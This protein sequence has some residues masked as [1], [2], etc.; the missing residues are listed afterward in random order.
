MS[1]LLYQRSLEQDCWARINEV[2]NREGS[3]PRSADPS[4][5]LPQVR[6]GSSELAINTRCP[7]FGDVALEVWAGDPRLAPPD[8][9]VVFDGTLRTVA[10]GFDVGSIATIF[11][12]KA[13]PG[14]YRVRAE[15]HRDDVGYVDAVRFIFPESPDLEGDALY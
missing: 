7:D 2:G 12:A 14:L 10:N 13:A 5:P 11:H 4:V 3:A 9:K 6:A 1:K 8:W 15:T